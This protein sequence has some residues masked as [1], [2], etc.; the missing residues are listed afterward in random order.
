[1]NVQ[2]NQIAVFEPGLAKFAS[3]NLRKGSFVRL[4]GEHPQPEISE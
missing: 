4:E 2:W 1:L 3:G